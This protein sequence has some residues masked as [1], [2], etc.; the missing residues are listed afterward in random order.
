MKTQR[1]I[2]KAAGVS[3]KTVSRVLN[4]D[5]LVKPETRARV[6]KVFRQMEYQPSVAAKLMRAKKS[7]IIGFVA[8]GVAMS[9]SSIDLIRGAQDVAWSLGKQM[10]LF[11]ILPG[12]DDGAHAEAQLAQFRAE[13]VIYATIYHRE[14][15]TPPKAER[16][17]LLNCF[18]SR[19]DIPTVLPDDYGLARLLMREVFARG[20]KRPYFFNLSEE[21]CAAGL[22]R[23]GYIDEGRAHGVDLSQRVRPAVVFRDGEH[24]FIVEDLLK[25]ILEAAERPDIIVCGQDIIAMQLYFAIAD[26]GFR[27]GQDI[28][29][30]SF[31][32]QAPIAEMLKPK[33]S[34]MQLPYYEMGRAAMEIACDMRRPDPMVR[35]VNGRFINRNSF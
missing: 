34:T 10:M 7:D 15:T 21:I 17:I 5:P 8:D 13:A 26:A 20:Y 9:N 27:V 28:G 22:R 3:L 14:L 16:S 23:Q 19:L 32:N 29:V 12:K 11:N 35:L 4:D 18:S 1:D 31:D 24:R 6:E 30:T 33:L 2:A 25:Q